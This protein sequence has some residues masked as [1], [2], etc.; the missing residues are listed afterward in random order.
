MTGRRLRT[1]AAAALAAGIAVGTWSDRPPRRTIIISGEYR[2]LSGDFHVHANPGD[3][4]LTPFALRDE[5]VRAGLDVVTAVNHNA[6]AAPRLIPYLPAAPELPLV[7]AA[8][9]ITNADYHMIA[10]GI[11]HR[12]PGSL[13]AVDAAAA[14]HAQGGVAIAA[15]PGRDFKGYD[16]RA[17]AAVDGTEVARADRREED[18]SDYVA[19]Y[20]RARR[21]HP[22]IAAIGS[23]D[24]HATPSVGESRTYLFVRER[25]VAGVLDA[26]RAGRTVAENDRGEMFGDP[27]LVARLAAARPAGRADPHPWWRRL[28]VALAWLGLA[29]LAVA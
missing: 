24:F 8:E 27:A 18:R 16:D 26:I 2:I 12:I 4:T 19:A 17:L 3:G 10:V 9:E 5:A 6:F 28:A 1:G 7:I 13:S 23:S 22:H 29:G 21:V 20:E 15:H 25:T 14:V 11:D